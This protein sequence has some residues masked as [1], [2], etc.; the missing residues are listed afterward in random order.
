ML[1]T[2]AVRTHH[3]FGLVTTLQ[4]WGLH[5]QENLPS[6]ELP[7][8]PLQPSIR[9]ARPSECTGDNAIERAHSAAAH[10]THGTRDQGSRGRTKDCAERRAF[11]SGPRRIGLRH[12]EESFVESVLVKNDAA[13]LAWG[14]TGLDTVDRGASVS[15][16]VE[17]CI[18]NRFMAWDLSGE[19]SDREGVAWGCL[20]AGPRM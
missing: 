12:V 2:T 15:N 18:Q 20:S 8:K 17:E 11:A 14:A 6:C 7:R 3:R 19:M 5:D 16:V 4:V 10:E 1:D 13:V 9:S